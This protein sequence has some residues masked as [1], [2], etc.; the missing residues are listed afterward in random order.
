VAKDFLGNKL[1]VG[2]KILFMMV[3][4]RS[5]QDGTVVKM[6]EK[7][8]TIL[9]Q[10]SD[11]ET[12]QFYSQLIKVSNHQALINKI[13]NFLEERRPAMDGYAE[14]VGGDLLNI[15]AILGSI[16]DSKFEKDYD[17]DLPI[18]FSIA[19]KNTHRLISIKLPHEGSMDR[20]LKISNVIGI[21]AGLL[22]DE[23]NTLKEKD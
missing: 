1:S 15:N 14:V 7:K 23:A 11:R 12:Y 6:G 9:P 22:N 21:L 3:G 16:I 19:N 8:A 4:Y 5:L 18:G 20:I 13:E 10:N 17:G 2:D